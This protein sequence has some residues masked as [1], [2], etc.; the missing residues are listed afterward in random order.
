MQDDRHQRFW[1]RHT[2]HPRRD[3][4]RLPTWPLGNFTPA[5]L[6][7]AVVVLLLATWGTR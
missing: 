7:A 1:Q 5:L 6:L 2:E 3:G 4:A